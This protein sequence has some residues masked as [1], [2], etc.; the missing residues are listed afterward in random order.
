MDKG[1]GDGEG[2]DGE[3]ERGGGEKGRGREYLQCLFFECIYAFVGCYWV[4][5]VTVIFLVRDRCTT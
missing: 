1:R 3:G 5:T 2:R 4:V